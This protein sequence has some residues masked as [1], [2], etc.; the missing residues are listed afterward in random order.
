MTARE[1]G[2]DRVRPIEARVRE[3]ERREQ[4]VLRQL[5]QRLGRDPLD[6]ALQEQDALTRVRV[7]GTRR[8]FHRQRSIQIGIADA[9]VRQARTMSERHPRR[10]AALLRLIR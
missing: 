6:R 5:L 7:L 1:V 3:P 9:P 8:K 4:P 2:L 10:D